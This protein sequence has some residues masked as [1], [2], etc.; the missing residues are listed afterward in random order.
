MIINLRSIDLQINY[1]NRNIQRIIWRIWV[2]ILGCQG[3]NNSIFNDITLVFH[4]KIHYL[5][6]EFRIKLHMKTD[7]T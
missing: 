7:I 6:W 5:M 2:L 4:R 3:L 1:L